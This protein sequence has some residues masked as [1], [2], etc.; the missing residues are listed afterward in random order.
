VKRVTLSKAAVAD[1]EA[2]DDYTIEHFGLD[3]AINTSERFREALQLL[4]EMPGSGQLREEI[5]PHGREFRYRAVLG[6]FVV[7]YEAVDDRIRV[8][9]VLHGARNLVAEL[10]RDAGDD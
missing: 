1:L 2:I 6:S 4:E 9:R 5:S 3:Q 8:A 10:E 7:V